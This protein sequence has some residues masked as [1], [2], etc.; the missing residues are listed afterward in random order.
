MS[1]LTLL[2]LILSLHKVAWFD[3]GITFSFLFS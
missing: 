2:T 3:D 1:I